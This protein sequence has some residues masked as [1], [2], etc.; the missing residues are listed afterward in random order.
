M[1]RTDASADVLRVALSLSPHIGAKTFDSLLHH[2]DQDLAA[3]LAAPQAE[4][5]R[6]KG[7]GQTIAREIIAIDL[8][9]VAEQMES[10]RAS[11]VATV[12]SGDHDYPT[13][14]R[15]LDQAPPILFARGNL[16]AALWA[17]T[18]AIVGTRNPTKEARYITLQLASKLARADCAVVSGLAL[19][20]DTAGHTGALSATGRTVAVLGSGVLN[21]YPESNRKLAARVLERGALISELHPRWGANAQR[22]VSRNRIISGLSQAVILVESNVDGGAMYAARF[23]REQG[24]PVYT[25]DLPASGN[26]ALIKNGAV[27]LNRDDPLDFPLDVIARDSGQDSRAMS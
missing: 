18:L 9:Q 14:L 2:F 15:E 20:I 19:G 27:V 21:I 6:V 8:T 25:F 16:G 22:L 5:L 26:Q 17:K 13:P 10:W 12:T 4:L 23:A 1:K 3:V 11:G 7:V 24:R